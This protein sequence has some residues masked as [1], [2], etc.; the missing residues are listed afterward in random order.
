[1]K[2]YSV[3]PTGIRLW[4]QLSVTERGKQTWQLLHDRITL[5]TLK[6]ERWEQAT[7]L[8][9]AALWTSLCM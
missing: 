5:E 3:C 7:A 8:G 6:K 1:M 4:V 2:E 9:S